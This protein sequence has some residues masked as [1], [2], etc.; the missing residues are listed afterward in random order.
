MD[1]A[2]SSAAKMPRPSLTK[3]T[4]QPSDADDFSDDTLPFFRPVHGLNSPTFSSPTTKPSPNDD[5]SLPDDFSASLPDLPPASSKG[6]A[7]FGN[8]PLLV[9]QVAVLSADLSEF[10]SQFSGVSHSLQILHQQQAELL[11]S[12][13]KHIQKNDEQIAALTGVVESAYLETSMLQLETSTRISE[14]A[15]KIKG[16]SEKTTPALIKLDFQTDPEPEV[17]DL[18]FSEAAAMGKALLSDRSLPLS[19]RVLSTKQL[20]KIDPTTFKLYSGKFSDVG[21]FTEKQLSDSSQVL[22]DFESAISST[23]VKRKR[24]LS[25]LCMLL[26]PGSQRTEELGNAMLFYLL[27]RSSTPSAIKDAAD[28]VTRDFILRGR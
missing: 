12:F 5:L 8:Q 11:T 9:Q 27:H 16:G 3:A 15:E 4:A 6:E 14:L 24:G 18:E 25:A 20:S 2:P 1:E 23:G 19:Y 21:L 10:K 13:G 7:I 28:M 26:G 17:V 22:K